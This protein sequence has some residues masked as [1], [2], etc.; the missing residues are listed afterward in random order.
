MLKFFIQNIPTTKIII[1]KSLLL[2]PI[3]AICF[4][5]IMFWP[6]FIIMPLIYICLL[7]FLVLFA[8]ILSK[9]NLLNIITVTTITLCLSF[10]VIQIF[11]PSTSAKDIF[12]AHPFNWMSLSSLAT[13]GNFLGLLHW[14]NK[15]LLASNNTTKLN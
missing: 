9:Y 6:F 14:Y 11:I 4:L 7:P 5:G 12:I 2:A 10:L 13:A 3:P 15:K 8:I 1:F